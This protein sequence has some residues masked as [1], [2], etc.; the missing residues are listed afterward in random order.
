M[1]EIKKEENQNEIIEISKTKNNIINIGKYLSEKKAI[2]PEPKEEDLYYFFYKKEIYNEKGTKLNN[3]QNFISLMKII[4]DYI[5]EKNDFIFL[6]FKKIDIDIIKVIFNGYISYDISDSISNEI[7]LETIKNIIPLFFSKNLFYLIYSKLSKIF[8]KF[9]LIEDKEKLFNNFCK[10]FELWK[11]I[12]NVNINDRPRV[13]SNYFTFIGKKHLL[14]LNKDNDSVF[15]F[16]EINI[17]IIFDENQNPFIDEIG[18]EELIRVLYF[19]HGVKS[20]KYKDIQ[21]DKDKENINNIS[22]KI[23]KEYINYQINKNEFDSN[24]NSNRFKIDSRSNFGKV[25]LLKNYI[26]KIKKIKID[27]DLKGET[28]EKYKYE[29]TPHEN[30]ESFYINFF[31]KEN[32]II[33]LAFEKKENKKLISSKIYDDILYE[34][35]RYYYGME[36][37]I[38]IMKII[39][40]FISFFKED[41]NKINQ[42]N[43]I[44]SEIMENIFKFIC[45]SEKNYE[46]FKKIIVPLLGALGEINHVYPN[47]KINNLY[48]KNVFSLLYIIIISSSLPFAIKKTYMKITGINNDDKLN[49]NFDDLIID[50]NQ[51][52]NSSYMWYSNILTIILEYIL[53]KFNDIN[54]VPR[55]IIKQLNQFQICLDKNTN[56]ELEQIKL[57]VS[58]YIKCCLQSLNFIINENK[59]ENNLF[60]NCNNIKD[61]SQYFELNFINNIDNIMLPLIMIKIYLNLINFETSP[62]KF[63][64]TEK[65]IISE[66]NQEIKINYYKHNFEN[67]FDIFEKYQIES[68]EIKN[69]IMKIFEDNTNNKDYLAKKFSFLTV[70]N[71]KVDTEMHL[72]ELIDIHGDYH[73]LM[74]NNFIFNKLWSDKKLFFDPEKKEKYLKYKSINYYTS[75]Y[76][77]PFI[78]P[79]L[80]YKHSYPSFS[81]FVIKDDFYIKEENQDEYNFNL[82]C[83]ELDEFN[84]EYEQTILKK[85]LKRSEYINVCMI[86]RTHHIKGILFICNNVECKI[87]KIVFYSYPKTK[88]DSKP[89]CNAS[90]DKI[91]NYNLKKD[92]IC[93]GAIFTCPEKYMN[94]KIVIDVKDI[95]L[96][97]RKI[98]FYRKTAFEIYTQNKS[99]FFNIDYDLKKNTEK[100]EVD[101]L[102][103][104]NRFAFLDFSPISIQ[105]QLIGLIRNDESTKDLNKNDK[106]DL[107]KD[108]DKFISSLFAQWSSN[109]SDT[110]IST[111]DL[112]LY[113]NILSN[114]SYIDIHQYPVFPVLFFYDKIKENDFNLVDRKLNKHIGFQTVTNRAKD[115]NNII[116]KTYNHSKEEEE[117]EDENNNDEPS[118]FATHFSNN[119]YVCNY[120]IRLFPYSFI[121]IE[122]QGN[123]FDS[124]NRLFFSIE[125]LLFNISSHNS[126]L[127]ELIPEIYYFPEIFWNINKL[128]FHKRQNGAQVEDVLMPK[129]ISK[130]DK[131]KKDRSSIN[132]NDEYE[133]T[134]YFRTFKFV[135]KM[136]NLLESKQIDIISWINIIFG[137]GQKHKNNKDNNNTYYFREESYIDYTDETKEKLKECR[138]NKL[139]LTNVEFGVT[140]VQIVFEGNIGKNRNKNNPYNLTVKENKDKFNK[141]CKEYVDI[142]KPPIIPSK[143][144]LLVILKNQL[145]KNLSAKKN[146]NNDKDNDK[147]N[148]NKDNNKDNNKENN[149]DNNKDNNNDK[150]KNDN[151]NNNDKNDKN[152]NLHKIANENNINENYSYINDI[153]S[154]NNI[155]LDSEKYIKCTYQ[156]EKI[157]M[158]GYTTGKIEV[159]KLDENK[160]F[161]L[162]SE[163]FDHNSEIKHINYNQR[164]NIICTSSKDGYINTYSF[165]NKLLTTIKNPNK[166]FF[167][168]VFLSSNPFPAIIAF[169]KENMCLYS[170][171]INGFTIKSAY[172]H[173]L[174]E[175]EENVQKDIYLIP[176]FNEKGGTFKDRLILIENNIETINEKEKEKENEKEKKKEKKK[177]KEKVNVFKCS[178]IRVPFFEKEEKIIEIK[179]K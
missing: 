168:L 91:Q 103:F 143:K 154:I 149:N 14:I 147:D 110:Q 111:L 123:G 173:K 63:E 73:K 41:E 115:R 1:E 79:L 100:I 38:P 31:P 77:R 60:E 171:S 104:I 128:N 76:Q 43:I 144:S 50:V 26:G 37:F 114:R 133:K 62:Y 71:Y 58:S 9:N 44:L 97:L 178:F 160:K 69:L 84:I 158:I 54:K 33:L 40:Y 32:D 87:K 170:Y 59:E 166:T 70:Q 107:S 20:L 119:V 134:D 169:E 117:E 12:Y 25:E 85:Y 113:L 30:G 80:D 140:P 17:E 176:N 164:L 155:F 75:N 139:M 106:D 36:S 116:C 177:E 145:S 93:F 7:L 46:N 165:P 5:K 48:S 83:P 135:E 161:E 13:N 34:D 156:N 4:N 152:D 51:L 10:I 16:K 124:P 137:S 138:N 130:I 150:D 66:D 96:I 6:Y 3:K 65:N 175:I 131:D 90:T 15:F 68:E 98:Y 146:K 56:N 61:I 11:L 55:N 172:I 53:L 78:F 88:A 167:D 99:Y 57:K 67:F 74:K 101:C 28:A 120:L 92:K 108:G 22:F 141:I 118:Y 94:R 127:R 86:K 2:F 102:T 95:K 27:I 132:L 19:E 45:Y 82:D 136:R 47:D 148:N 81:N 89:F 122:L 109:N 21:Y 112:L 29:I 105:K 179:Q 129:D 49:L 52:N 126:D 39:K 35:I 142:I 163:L 64:E 23:N 153:S 159:Y 162:I 174:L 18:N 121:S 24:D 157:K 42:L 125:D 72:S 8:R 151:N